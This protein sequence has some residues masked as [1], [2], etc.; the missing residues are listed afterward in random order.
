MDFPRVT[1]PLGDLKG[2][3]LKTI[4]NKEYFSFKGIPYAEPP[5][6]KLRFKVCK[7]IHIIKL[8]YLL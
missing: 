5:I 6:G 1:L 4:N 7:Y 3:K 8:K 2:V